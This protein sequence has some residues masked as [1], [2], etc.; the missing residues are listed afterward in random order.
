MIHTLN[1]T[2]GEPTRGNYRKSTGK[3]NQ[4]AANSRHFPLE[5]IDS[6][7]IFAVL[8]GKVNQILANP[9]HFPGID[10]T[11]WTS[12][13]IFPILPAAEIRFMPSHAL[14]SSLRLSAPP[15][16]GNANKFALLSASDYL[17]KI[18]CELRAVVTTS[19]E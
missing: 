5:N 16:T 18:Y 15:E 13:Y 10:K 9:G 2:T 11:T 19:Q 1:G 8:P 4:S 6:T 17:C 3:V 12:A 7:A 14:G